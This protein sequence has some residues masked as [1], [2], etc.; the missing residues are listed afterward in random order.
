MLTEQELLMKINSREKMLVNLKDKSDTE[1][2]GLT[3]ELQ[4]IINRRF[5][6]KLRRKHMKK[7][8]SI[9]RLETGSL[10]SKI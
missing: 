3:K 1:I 4:K 5:F 2:Q 9:G 10:I 8:G 6:W 7:E